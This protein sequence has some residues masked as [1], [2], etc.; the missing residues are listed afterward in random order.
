MAFALLYSLLRGLGATPLAANAIAL[1][2]TMGVNFAA[3]RHLTF[4]AADGPL[5]RQLAQYT[6]A[7]VLGLS[8]SSLILAA[9]LALLGHLHG[10]LETGLALFAGLG[11]TIVRFAL[12]RT[13][14]F[15]AAGRAADG[16]R[17]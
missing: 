15:D 2:T 1:L 16:A 13:W 17:P 3:N 7:Y 14:V 6:G 9:G 11:A 8:A 12:M 10:I 4:D 5:L